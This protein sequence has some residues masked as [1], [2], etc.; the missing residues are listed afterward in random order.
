MIITDIKKT[1]KNKTVLDNIS[2]E[3][4]KGDFII[5]LGI[6]GSGK[7]TL[8]KLFSGL[9]KTDQNKEIKFNSVAYLPEKFTLPKTIS[10]KDYIKYLE[11]DNRIDLSYYVNYLDIP[12]KLI[13]ELSKGNLQKLGLLY[14]ISSKQEYLL[15]DEPTEG[16]D[17]D[18]K[19]KFVEILKDLHQKGKTIIISSHQKKDYQKIKYREIVVK[20]GKIL[21]EMFSE[22]LQ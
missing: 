10:V 2:L 21:D 12:F 8:I 11:H 13:K 17:Q 6:N 16:M 18:L 5:L 4:N 20:E 7:S 1:Y 19:K 14:L 15:L 22:T 9:I 3:I